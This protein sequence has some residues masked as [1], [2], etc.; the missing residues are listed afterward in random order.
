M[1]KIS[2]VLVAAYLICACSKD[3]A[4]ILQDNGIQG[5]VASFEF[6]EPLSK[7]NLVYNKSGLSF[8]W[9]AGDKVAVFGST[10]Q[11]QQIPLTI[12]NVSG[13]QVKNAT[14]TISK[15]FLLRKGSE[16]VAYCPV[17]NESIFLTA[18]KVPFSYTG[19]VQEA[20]S[21]ESTSHLGKVDFMV[22]ERTTPSDDNVALFS[23]KHKCCPV[24]IKASNLPAG[25]YTSVALKASEENFSLDGTMSL[26]EGTMDTQT[27]SDE[28]A[29]TLKGGFT[30]E[31]GGSVNAWIMAAPAELAGLSLTVVLTPSEGSPVEFAVPAEK[32][33]NFVDGKAYLF[34]VE[35][36]DELKAVDLGLSVKWANMN[37][38]ANSVADYGGLYAWGESMEKSDYDSDTYSYWPDGK[39]LNCTKYTGGKDGDGLTRLQPEDDTATKLLGADWRMPT[40]AEF[41]ELI[42]NCV[43]TEEMLGEKKAFRF[44]SKKN[45]NSLYFLRNGYQIKEV[46]NGRGLNGV[47]NSNYWSSESL[48]VSGTTLNQRAD[49]LS[50]SMYGKEVKTNLS[51]NTRYHGMGVRA[52][53]DK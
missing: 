22:S 47:Y 43:I 7:T 30:V 45:G 33:K 8:F 37:V 49:R 9:A 3:N 51:A 11:N 48:N 14:F 17:T 50:I 38:G 28:I 23:F 26:F 24:L 1:K 25:T 2:F 19:Q 32:V 21:V 10:G 44:T 46:L 15:D 6:D 5:Q 42:S 13:Q 40:N 27:Y 52:V 35:K 4:A 18:K 20:N 36:T 39:Y 16:Y 53:T 31:E 29:V 41:E 12:Q 34:A